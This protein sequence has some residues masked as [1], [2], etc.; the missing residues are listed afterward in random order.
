VGSEVARVPDGAQVT[1]DAE[2]TERLGAVELLGR[3]IGVGAPD[4]EFGRWFGRQRALQQISLHFVAARAKLPPERLLRIE[5]GVS[6]LVSD[7][8]GRATAGALAAAL[9]LDPEE[10][11]RRLPEPAAVPGKPWR[12]IE[13]RLSAWDL[14]WILEVRPQELRLPHWSSWVRPLA[15]GF[16]LILFGSGLALGTRWWT[17]VSPAPTSVEPVAVAPAPAVPV[18]AAAPAAAAAEE[19]PER[20]AAQGTAPVYRTDYIRQLL[21]DEGR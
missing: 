1:G 2:A 14:D 7:E 10:A 15:I 9:G 19:V 12:M 16:A 6:R 18:P 8:H 5:S 17:S 3:L 13:R 11:L 20:S 21:A 4:Q